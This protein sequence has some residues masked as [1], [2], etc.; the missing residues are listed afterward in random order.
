MAYTAEV[1]QFKQWLSACWRTWELR[2]CL[3]CGGEVS[4]LL[5]GLC[6]PRELLVFGLEGQRS[7]ILMSAR[8]CG[9]IG[10]RRVSDSSGGGGGSRGSTVNRIDAH[11]S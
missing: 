7:W 2:S 9:N 4:A 6:R 3:V 1:G 10:S 11:T 5:T 8:K